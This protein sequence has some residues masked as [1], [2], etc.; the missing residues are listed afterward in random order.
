M[1]YHM[2]AMSLSLTVVYTQRAAHPG[3]HSKWASDS[4]E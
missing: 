3:G 2:A 4:R 1:F